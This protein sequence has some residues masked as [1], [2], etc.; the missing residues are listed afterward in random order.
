MYY[1]SYPYVLLQ[2]EGWRQEGVG[3]RHKYCAY[4]LII[5]R[6][7]HAL[8]EKNVHDKFQDSH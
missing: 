7:K 8:E 6:Q 3:N 5:Y 4:A 2:A 1:I